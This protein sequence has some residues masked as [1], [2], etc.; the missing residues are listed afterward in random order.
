MHDAHAFAAAAGAGFDQHRETD[1]PGF[2]GQQR[3]R[4]VGLVVTR[5]QGHTGFGHQLFGC[6]FQTHGFNGRH[7][8]TDEHQTGAGTRI[9]KICVFTQKTITGVNRLSA[10]FHGCIQDAMPLQITVC[11]GSA[12]YV[13]RF[14]TGLHMRGLRVRIRIHGHG[15]HT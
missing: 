15:A 4:L 12:A 7:T 1:A 2:T 5:H 11:H 6:R 14:I 8:G 13:H 10:G 9:R 3:R